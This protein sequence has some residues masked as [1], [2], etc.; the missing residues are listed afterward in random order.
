[1]F[2]IHSWLENI[3][4]QPSTPPLWLRGIEPMY[5]A[6]S[7]AHLKRRAA[8]ITSPPLPMISIGNITAGGSGKTPFVLWLAEQLKEQGYAPVILCRG[9][10]GSGGTSPQHIQSTDSAAMV[11]DEAKMLANLSD[12]PVIAA[13]DRI[14]GSQ[15]AKT[16]GN[17][18]ILDDGFQYRHLERCCDIVLIP[19]EGVGNG[20]GIP[21]GPLREPISSLTRADIIVR[22][23]SASHTEPCQALSD[24]SEWQWRT[25]T[26][27]LTDIIHTGASKPDSV[28]AIT[29]I[30]RPQRFFDDLKAQ[31][32]NLAGTKSYPDHHPFNQA[33]VTNILSQADQVAITAKD[34]VKLAPLWPNDRPLW[35][36]QQQGKAE[37]TLWHAIQAYLK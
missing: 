1:M 7:Q 20:H 24:Q 23:A 21:A 22:S 2:N 4:W 5:S 19:A 3:W 30:A 37:T 31:G 12:C 36:L 16:L 13:A 28:F 27:G 34:A 35:L 26:V 17:I 6:I 15:M 11:G 33:D 25:E 10:G 18:L 14:A 9:D 29:A 32:L 8:N